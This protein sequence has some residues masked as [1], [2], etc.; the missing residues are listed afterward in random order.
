MVKLDVIISTYSDHRALNLCLQ[1]YA[2][3]A[4]KE[5]RVHV[6]N[7]G[8]NDKLIR[9]TVKPYDDNL[10]IH[11]HY[12][13]PPSEKFR[14]SQARNLALKHCDAPRVLITDGDCIPLSNMTMAHGNY[15]DRKIVIFGL[16]HHVPKFY[17]DRLRYGD[18]TPEGLVFV[19]DHRLV[20]NWSS[21]VYMAIK[22]PSPG[23]YAICFGCNVSYPTKVARDIGGFWEELVGWGVEDWD[24]ARRL[25]MSGCTVQCDPTMPILHLDHDS[26]PMNPR[27][28]EMVTRATTFDVPVR[29]GG[30]I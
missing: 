29:N 24:M 4:D 19:A 10:D 23:A 13:D 25:V 27:A 5:F 14:L 30:P 8:G 3:Q 9:R 18:P 17:A 21:I 15:G 1:G 11:Y 7:D 22:A 28:A 26:P 6:V 20:S 12:L 2:N 16:R